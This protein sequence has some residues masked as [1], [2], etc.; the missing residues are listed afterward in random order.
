MFCS[1]HTC[2]NMRCWS[3]YKHGMHI[4]PDAKQPKLRK[5]QPAHNK[6]AA[7]AGSSWAF[8][9]GLL[10]YFNKSLGL[11]FVLLLAPADH[12]QQDLSCM[13]LAHHEL[14]SERVFITRVIITVILT[15]DCCCCRR[16]P[17]SSNLGCTAAPHCLCHQV[18]GVWLTCHITCRYCTSKTLPWCSIMFSLT[19]GVY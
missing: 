16:L 6:S 8:N 5:C 2:C 13:H 4:C 19:P 15:H 17:A 1:A 3:G 9:T 10:D 11:M 12:S 18:N 7:A 14:E